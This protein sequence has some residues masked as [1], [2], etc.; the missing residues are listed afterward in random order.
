MENNKLSNVLPQMSKS[1]QIKRKMK[2]T[3]VY[4]NKAEPDILTL[5]VTLANKLRLLQVK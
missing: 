2:I 4:I 3:A 5:S 1:V